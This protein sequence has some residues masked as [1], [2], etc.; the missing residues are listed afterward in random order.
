VVARHQAEPAERAAGGH[1]AAD[2]Q[3]LEQGGG[4]PAGHETDCNI[5]GFAGGHG[6]VVDRGQGVAALGG[7]AVGVLEMDLDE[8][9]GLEIQRLAVITQELVVA[10]G[11]GQH[12][13]VD[14][15][16][17]ELNRHEFGKQCV[18]G[19]NPRGLL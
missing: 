18:A 9:S 7:S 17:G 15:L 5:N 16:E 12:A 2:V 4:G 3:T 14:Q 10:D 6:V 1:V 11:G 19:A 8:L 13:P